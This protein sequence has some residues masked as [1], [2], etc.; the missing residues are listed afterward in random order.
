MVVYFGLNPP[1][2]K[3]ECVLF[4]RLLRT[5]NKKENSVFWVNTLRLYQS[6]SIISNHLLSTFFT[7]SCV[8]SFMHSVEISDKKVCLFR[9]T[10]M[11]TMYLFQ[12]TWEV[13]RISKFIQWYLQTYHVSNSNH[14]PYVHVHC[15]EN[16]AFL[17][18]ILV[19]RQ[20]LFWNFITKQIDNSTRRKWLLIKKK[21]AIRELMWIFN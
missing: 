21:V 15:K 9:L 17:C 1:L 5:A 14:T 6:L 20:T 8:G 11:Y 19:W 2:P 3:K 13:I 4:Q 12:C 18:L 16:I 10:T 7:Y